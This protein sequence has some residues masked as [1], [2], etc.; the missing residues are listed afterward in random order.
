MK[1]SVAMATYN[2]ESFVEEQLLSICR[3]TRKPDEI[4]VSDDGSKDRTLEIVDRVSKSEDA[5]GIKFVVLTDNPRHGY[6]GN[7]EWAIKHT[8]GDLI[9]LSDQ[10][11]VWIPEKVERI[12]SVKTKHPDA[13]CIIHGAVLIDEFGNTLP[14]EFHKIVKLDKLATDS[15][16]TMHLDRESFLE[17]SVSS[18]L[19]AGMSMCISRENLVNILPFPKTKG[20]H[21]LWIGFSAVFVDKCFY[22]A[23]QLVKYRLHNEN[24]CGSSS[25][26][27]KL[28]PKVKRVI[29]RIRSRDTTILDSYIVG[30]AMLLKLEETDVPTHTA[31]VTARRVVEIGEKQLR[32]YQLGGVRGVV[33]LIKLFCTDTRYRRSGTAT[34]FYQVASVLLKRKGKI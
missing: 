1:V 24:T 10:D 7:F 8:T 16:H 18:V 21:D 23:E 19:S 20:L 29:H 3:Q 14:G 27:I 13:A 9:F 30:K 26:K 32:A 28:I 6:C 2:G 11:D 12:C 22:L 33:E 25:R 34:F 15:D 5:E 4:V 31:Y 17:R